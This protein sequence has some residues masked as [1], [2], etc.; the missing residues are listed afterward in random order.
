VLAAGGGGDW[1]RLHLE[2]SLA[3]EI[4]VDVDVDVDLRGSP[5]RQ[6]GRRSYFGAGNV[7]RSTLLAQRHRARIDV[8]NVRRRLV[9][10]LAIV[11]RHAALNSD[12]P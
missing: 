11:A 6:L 3:I 7:D 9:V 4:E 12:S 1:F 8:R 5:N 10:E 2:C